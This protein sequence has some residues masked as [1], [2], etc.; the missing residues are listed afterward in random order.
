MNPGEAYGMDPIT[1]LERQFS[2]RSREKRAAIFR[3]LFPLD[4]D[5]K[6]LDLG[7]ETGANI[8]A[9]L[10][11]TPVRPGNVHIADIDA[12]AVAQG[13]REFGFTPVVIGEGE[14]LPFPDGF[15]DI[16]YCSSVIEHVTVPKTI[17][18][19]LR[20]GREFRAASRKRQKAFAG[21]IKRLGKRYFVQTPNRHFPIE[22]HTW[23][24]FIA[25]L[26]RRLLIPT[27]RFTKRFWVKAASPDFH[28]LDR[29][30]MARLFDG[31]KIVEEKAFGFTKSLIAVNTGFAE[32]F[33]GAIETE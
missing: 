17:I 6:I 16:V 32:A 22:S 3:N 19:E 33:S 30:E 27:L 2:R 1:L 31:A 4:Q 10:E 13:S 29:E 14:A 28:L 20:S 5:T 7:S 26:P 15:F 25:W 9:V 21:E 23:L 12:Q 24:P 18:W 8:R 11:G